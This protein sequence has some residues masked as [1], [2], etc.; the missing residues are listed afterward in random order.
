[1]SEVARLYTQIALLQ[2]G[3]QDLPA[4]GLLLALTVVG[5][6]AVSAVVC[7]LLPDLQER[8]L[9]SLLI[10]IGCT[11]VWYR[12]LLQ[13]A[14]RAERFLQTTTAV[15]GYR[16][17]L[18]PL[19]IGAGWLIE[20]YGNDPQWQLPFSAACAALAVWLLV[21]ASRV[22]RAA[23]EWA[24]LY[25][26]GLVLAEFCVEYLLISALVPAPGH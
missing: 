4:S 9:P 13:A 24:M 14:G 11:L 10:E 12:L 23:L 18:A 19:T 22:L 20:R 1:M 17:V 6:F 21:V 8:W 15:F 7:G 25:C 2:R 26:V 5:Y 3:P 16:L